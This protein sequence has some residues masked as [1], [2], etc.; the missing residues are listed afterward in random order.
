MRTL[1]HTNPDLKFVPVYYHDIIY[2]HYRE[3]FTLLSEVK[4]HLLKLNGWQTI[5]FLKK[6]IA[7]AVSAKYLD[8]TKAMVFIIGNLDEAYQMTRN[9]DPDISADEFHE[10]S[11]K[12]SLPDIKNALKERF[13]SEQ[14]SRPGNNHIIYPALDSKSFFRI[15]DIE[16]QKINNEMIAEFGIKL[17]FHESIRQ[18]IYDEGVCPTQGTRPLFSTIHREAGSFT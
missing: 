7:N 4:E 15:I 8:C 1:P 18:I 6:L 3:R 9:F 12:I 17:T 14:I 5:E 11:L 2:E 10:E 13:R 16:L